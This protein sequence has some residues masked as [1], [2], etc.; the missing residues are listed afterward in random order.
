MRRR[1]GVH[2]INGPNTLICLFKISTVVSDCSACVTGV[3]QSGKG[4]EIKEHR[5]RGS[6]LKRECRLLFIQA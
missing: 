2:A 1:D 3:R 5:R 4:L 6:F